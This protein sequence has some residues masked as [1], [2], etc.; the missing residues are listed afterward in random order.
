MVD[1]VFSIPL[2]ANLPVGEPE[3]EAP[4]RGAHGGNGL[5]S[6]FLAGPENRLIAVAIAALLDESAPHY[7]PLIIHGL[8]GTG[9]SHLARGLAAKRL[10]RADADSAAI[11]FITGADFAR[12]L[13]EAIQ[14]ESTAS[15]RRR[16]RR[17]SLLI[18]DD[19]TQLATK[20]VAQQELIHTLDAVIDGGG[21]VVVTSRTAPERMNALCAAL[22][23]R[24]SAGLTVSLSPPAAAARLALVER[25]ASLRRI[26]LPEAAA[27]T[28]ADGLSATAPEL[29][30]A[31]AEVQLQAQVERTAIDVR[32]VRRFLADRQLRLRP[33]LRTIASL[34]AKYFGLRMSDL[35]SPSRRRAVVQARGVAM[36]LARQL[37]DKSL[38]RIGDYFGGRDHTTV[39]HSVNSTESRLRSDPTIRRAAADIRKL[40]AQG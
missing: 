14:G 28:L 32:G 19:L 33:S 40:L 2:V 31:L 1:A 36:H 27:R 7:N 17:A 8:S 38:E 22:R 34:T 37:T 16:F 39:L 15:F 4:A 5:G 12:L 25:F 29:S 11:V 3:S 13:H 21:Q 24:L 18:V 20:P 26:A 10:L 9:K 23:S 35:R 30:G 6:E